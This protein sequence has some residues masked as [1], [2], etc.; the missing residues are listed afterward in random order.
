MA[1]KHMKK[2]KEGSGSA[3]VREMQ[4]KTTMMHCVTPVGMLSIQQLEMMNAGRIAG[5]EWG[6]VLFC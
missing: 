5:W 2:K 4:I 3:A 6:A 1:K